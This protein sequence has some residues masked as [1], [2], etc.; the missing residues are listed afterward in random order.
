MQF[1]S[2]DL[3]EE[4]SITRFF[5][6]HYFEMEASFI[7]PKEIHD[8]WE[9]VYLDQGEL[10]IVTDSNHRFLRQGEVIFYKPNEV[11][12][13]WACNGT[14][15]VLFIISFECTA[16]CMSY[17]GN[18]TFV[19]D[20][21][22]KALLSVMLEEGLQTFDPPIDSRETVSLKGGLQQ[23][24]GAEQLI[25]ITLESLLI[26]LIRKGERE[27]R[28]KPMPIALENRDGDLASSIIDYLDRHVYSDLSL[29]VICKQFALGRSHLQTLFM[30]KTG[31]GIM[32]YYNNLKI[33]KAQ[34]LIREEH[35]NF[36]EIAERLGYSSIHYF[37]RFFKKKTGITPTQYA[38]SVKA[39]IPV[40][41]GI[42]KR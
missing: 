3:Q 21:K 30:E 38:R 41:S 35:Y 9:F 34:T 37:S 15:P 26:R 14:A 25:K 19:L 36:T 32:E 6:F 13:G 42:G 5:S 27:H 8:F 12:E 39:R 23:R 24:F 17:F 22:E 2:Y 40:A 33:K 16:P 7:A 1:E 10:E 20:D 29:S 31:L 4:L 11:H 18:K 28:D